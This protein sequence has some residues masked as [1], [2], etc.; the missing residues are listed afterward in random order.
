VQCITFLCALGLVEVPQDDIRQVVI[1]SADAA[2]MCLLSRTVSYFEMLPGSRRTMMTGLEVGDAGD[3]FGP[4]HRWRLSVS[5]CVSIAV[6]LKSVPV[7]KLQLRHARRIDYPAR[8]L[9][10]CDPAARLTVRFA[11]NLVKRFSALSVPTT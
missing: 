1:R 7:S 10:T 4:L 5:A 11:N 8:C 9:A 2:L 6:S 3:A